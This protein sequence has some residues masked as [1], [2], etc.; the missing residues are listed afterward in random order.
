M[1]CHR[2]KVVTVEQPVQLFA[3]DRHQSSTR[4]GPAKPLLSQR[5]VVENESVVLRLVYEDVERSSER[6]MPELH[7]D[8][9]GQTAV[10]LSDMR[11]SA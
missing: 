7:L 9:G 10:T 6:I 2:G 5:L 11:C 4:L 3:I 8:D 1:G